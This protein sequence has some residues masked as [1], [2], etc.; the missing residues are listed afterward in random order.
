MKLTTQHNIP[1]STQN[2]MIIAF[3]EFFTKGN[4][5]KLKELLS[6]DVY[7]ILYNRE[8]IDGLDAVIDY[9]KDWQKRVG[10]TFECQVKWSAQFASA[11]VYFI[12]EKIHQAYIFGI[13]DAKIV[14]ILLTPRKFSKIGFSIDEIPYN[15]GFIR[16]NAPKQIP[17]LANHYFCPICGKESEKLNWGTGVIFRDGPEWGKKTGLIINASVCPKCNIVCEVNPDRCVTKVLS[18]TFDQRQKADMRMT[19]EQLSEY[20]DNTMG[21]KKTIS[22]SMLTSKTNEL[23]RQGKAFHGLLIKVA[24]RKKA[25]DFIKCLDNISFGNNQVNVHIANY[26]CMGIGD[27]SYFFIGKGDDQD[28]EIHKHIH[29]EPSV[30]AAWQIYILFTSSTVMPVF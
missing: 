2:A 20:V 27:E 30:E 6:E 17:P 16:A 15:V 26:E 22:C 5:T 24:E 3:A 1:D 9:F 14:K 12:S 25:D 19:K 29:A 18:M 4:F 13:E 8:R 23:S 11:E 21:N 7:L 28:K 10:Y